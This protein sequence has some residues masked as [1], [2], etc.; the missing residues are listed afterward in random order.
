MSLNKTLKPTR[1][2]LRN[3][4]IVAHVDH[5]KT[6]LVDTML[7]QA[8]TFRAHQEHRERIMD[9]MDLER[10]RGITIMA[11]NAALRLTHPTGNFKINILDTPGHADFGGEVERV[12]SMADGCLLLVD[13]AE[14]VLP[15]TRFVLSKALEANLEPIVVINKIDRQDARPQAVLDEVY[16]LFIDLDA[17]E[18]QLEFPVI[19]C[20]GREGIAKANLDD[21]SSDL[22][23]LF[24]AIVGSVPPPRADVAA[25]L[26]LLVSNLDYND[27][28][29]RLA[30][31]RIVSGEIKNQQEVALCALDG[32]V[33]NFKIAQLFGFEGLKREAVES[34]QAGDI[35]AIAG[36]ENLNIGE[37]I[38]D[39]ENP[40]ALPPLVVDEPTIA[41]NFSSN[42]SPFA[43]REGK[44]VTGRHLRER[45]A[46]EVLSNVSIRVETTEDPDVYKVSGRGELQMAILI[47][48][49][50][51]EGYE[52]QVSR[53]EVVTHE[54]N[55]VLM[56]PIEHV[57]IDCPDTFI[58]VVTEALGRRKGTMMKMSNHGGGRVRLEFE[59][60]SRGLIGFRSQF[61]TDTKGMGLLN[62]LFARF[63][64]WSGPIPQRPSGVLVADRAGAATSYAIANLQERGVIFV[65]P[66]TPVYEGM[67]VGENARES[68]LH[69]NIVKEKHLTNI[70]SSTSDIAVRL[71]PPLIMS[72]EQALEF[73]NDDELLEATPTSL[74]L[75]KKSLQANK[76]EK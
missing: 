41:M 75:R 1:D 50:R 57:F 43:G 23:P 5:G 74:R 31:G 69:V 13:A 20:I 60:P 18:E 68:D 15:Q 40:V 26:Q 10:E 47:E 34:A 7:E 49:M 28:V 32:S 37:T 11:K 24:D 22:M 9:S 54:E 44:F 8:H 53:P 76:R 19:Y 6:T 14:G 66:G 72:L 21:E 27:Y 30:I 45:L 33:K 58:G 67:V 4:A 48:T 36:I 65:E 55:G 2:D 64:P 59:I 51:R 46:K 52:V 35:V 42:T 38:A 73:I 12:L 70:R 25:P 56:E 39:P 29:G 62:T 61:L 17:T 71:V 16:S 3:I 63:A